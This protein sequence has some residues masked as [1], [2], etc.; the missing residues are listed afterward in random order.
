MT[1]ITLQ[2]I[3]LGPFMLPW[4]LTILM[5]A[6]LVS[7]IIGKLTY[8]YFELET[9]QWSTFKDSIWTGIWLGVLCARIGFVLLN[10]EVYLDHPIEIIKI[11]DKGFNLYLGV[12]AAFLWIIWK[13]RLLKKSFIL[14]LLTIFSLLSVSAH[15][16]YRQIQLQYQQFPDVQLL[17]LQQQPIKLTKYL[18][19][20]TVINLWASWCPP[21][22]REMPV[23]SEAQK[24][25]PNVKL[26]FINQNEDA[27]TVQNYLQQHSLQLDE[28][29]L[30]TNGST[31]QKM[32]MFGLPST[33][34]FDAQ[35]K[36]ID[37]H[38]GEI[39]HAALHQ[40]IQNLVSD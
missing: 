23:L 22:R 30:D 25:Y 6:I 26:I 27:V 37:T 19:K 17:N 10:L 11:Q 13:N 15:Y 4:T 21:C 16:T 18:G 20:P 12:I 3:H 14:L 28:V 8:R 33:L 40:K 7:V 35:G 34:F 39:T 31:A 5:V 29:L 36:L 9:S 1:M 38:M 2:A 32:G 24:K